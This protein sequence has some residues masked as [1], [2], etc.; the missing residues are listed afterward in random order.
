MYF[1]ALV[2]V[3][4]L[5][6]IGQHLPALRNL[7]IDITASLGLR[8]AS[9][10]DLRPLLALKFQDQGPKLNVSLA[11]SPRSRINHGLG[12]WHVAQADHMIAAFK[13]LQDPLHIAQ[14][15]GVYL[16]CIRSLAVIC[17]HN[18]GDIVITLERSSKITPRS[19]AAMRPL[20]I[21]D[22]Q[23]WVY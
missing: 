6:G 12:Q 14:D 8:R 5:R 1:S 20:F 13:A 9:S 23:V 15:L 7:E 18:N 2:V 16:R 11:S 3:G 19:F 10:I 4:W 17:L 21:T 22:E